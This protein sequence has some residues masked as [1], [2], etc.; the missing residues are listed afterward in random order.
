VVHL[1]VLLVPS[2]LTD[3]TQSGHILEDYVCTI[4]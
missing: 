4:S 1:L 3:L 2:V